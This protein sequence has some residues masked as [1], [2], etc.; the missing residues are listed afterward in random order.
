VAAMHESSPHHCQR[1]CRVSCAPVPMGRRPSAHPS[2]PTP[3]KRSPSFSRLS[4]SCCRRA[5]RH[6]RHGRQAELTAIA[7]LRGPVPPPP[8][9]QPQHPHPHLSRRHSLPRLLELRPH[10]Y[11]WQAAV[12]CYWRTWPRDHGRLLVRLGP[13]ASRARHRQAM[14]PLSH[15][16]R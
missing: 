12:G 4:P 11:R 1:R 13:G 2:L 3:S 14:A 6:G 15:L 10:R 8:L 16:R 7:G 9:L 5:A